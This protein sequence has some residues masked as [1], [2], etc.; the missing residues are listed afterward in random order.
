MLS[1]VTEA[2]LRTL[3]EFMYSGEATID[4]GRLDSLLKVCCRHVIYRCHIHMSHSML[5]GRL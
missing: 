5:N 3:I 4:Q 2:E 1:D